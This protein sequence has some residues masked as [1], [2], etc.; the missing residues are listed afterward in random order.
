MGLTLFTINYNSKRYADV[1][2]LCTPA[3]FAK[4]CIRIFFEYRV[5]LPAGSEHEVLQT[6]SIHVAI[7]PL[8]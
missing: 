1:L 7:L 6:G 5:L 3:H 4:A 2:I 8:Q